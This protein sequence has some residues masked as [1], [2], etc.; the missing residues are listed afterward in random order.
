M[1]RSVFSSLTALLLLLAMLLS[2]TSCFEQEL[3]D[4]TITPDNSTNDPTGDPTNDPTDDPTDDPADNPEHVCV[5]GEWNVI[6]EPTNTEDG[7]RER[8]CACGKTEQEVVEASGKEYYIQ[9]RN[10]KTA[11]YPAENGYN[12]K[13]GLLTLPTPEAEGYVFIGWYTASVGGE[14]VD[15]IP[16][17]SKKNY[18][19][20]AHWDLVTYEITYKNVPD[21]TNITSYDI[22]DRIRLVTPKWSGL[23]F[24]HWSDENGNV[25]KPDE[26]ITAL[27]ERM[28][29]DLTLTANWKVLRNIAT[30]ASPDRK[31]LSAYSETEGKIYFVYD[32]GTIQHVVLDNINPNM[33]YKYEN[34][35]INLTLSE[36]VT[37]SKERAESIADTVSKSISSTNSWEQS[38]NQAYTNT[39]NWNAHVGADLDIGFGNGSNSS[40]S[41][42]L[43][44][45]KGIK[46]IL[47]K[48]LS[49]AFNFNMN[50]SIDGSYDWGG[51]TSETLEMTNSQSGSQTSTEEQSHTVTSSIAYK[52]E[53]TS[54]IIENIT[55][56][57]DLP[58]GYYAYVHAGD[59]RVFAVVTYEISTGCLYLN[60]YSRL[61]NMH[62]M[63]M[64]YP[65]VNELNNPTVEG[66]D[67]VLPEEEIV[68]IVENSYYVKYDANGGTGTMPTTMHSIDGKEQL[69]ANQF[70]KPGY[71][72]A[73]W[74]L[75]TENGVTILLD[76]QSVTNIG[77][78][79][80][81]VTLKALW[82]STEPVWIEKESG[83]HYYANMPSGFDKNNSLYSKYNNEALQ[84]GVQ[85]NIKIVVTEEK[86]YTYI[87]WHWTV[88][89]K[90]PYN[91]LIGA[92]YGEVV[93][94][95]KTAIYFAAFES[96]ADYGHTDK[97]GVKERS[98]I[99]YCDRGN[100]TDCSWWWYRIPVYVQT[101]TIYELGQ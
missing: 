92:Y 7:L 83:S 5:F 54:E 80:K 33:Y 56:S 77:D 90:A 93:K 71:V 62:A 27:P 21:N 28:H 57:A 19:L 12:S 29:G 40:E 17:G 6:K 58:E 34:Y 76:G 75:E 59:I 48:T 45:D 47:S 63:V 55:I 85:D 98:D 49:K 61:D 13:D 82:T 26:N 73:G 1:K 43:E 97:T 2:V 39:T 87:Y 72:F 41:G 23:V 24:T 88:E 66:L 89:R 51:G 65:T 4:I 52:D 20:Y 95:G 30:P 68:N 18:I 15:Y 91:R 9:Y 8:T 37:I 31:L 46:A 14:L 86:V 74:Q 67:F 69:A 44:K 11:E 53:I 32:I 36:T 60:T 96:T 38:I 16:E 79:L 50:F 100:N 64:Y 22:E 99:Y 81:T 35:S 25:Y 70:A 42:S 84:S 10:L 78:P 101:Y 94:S 3:P